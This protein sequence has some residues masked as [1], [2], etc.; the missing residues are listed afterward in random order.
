MRWWLFKTEPA[1]YSWDDL[2]RDGATCWE[3]VRNYQARNL[4]RDEV[5]H[6]DLVFVYHSV[7][8][9]QE[10]AGVAR[11]VREA[12]PDHHAQDPASPYFDRKATPDDPRWLM[13]DIEPVR[14]LDPPISRD[15]LKA[16]P[17]LADMMLLRRGSRLSV[18]PV[19]D[20]HAKTILGMRGVSLRSLQ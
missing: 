19:A 9:P 16:V 18:Q 8:Q 7:V 15:E 1:T 4:L 20:R 2:A 14:Q 12:Y 11:V 17:I 3:G 13:V 10:I 6:G 5:A